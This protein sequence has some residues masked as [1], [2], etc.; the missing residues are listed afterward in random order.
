MRLLI[1]FIAILCTLLPHTYAATR[2]KSPQ[3]MA[4]TNART[5]TNSFKEKQE[6]S[7]HYLS[8]DVRNTSDE[9]QHELIL[10]EEDKQHYSV[11]KLFIESL[12]V[13]VYTCIYGGILNQ[14]DQDHPTLSQSLGYLCSSRYISIRNIRI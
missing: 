5:F 8:S 3:V 9:T 14:P 13:L 10:D 12:P 6:T 7:H 4:G 2:E 1:T 11:N